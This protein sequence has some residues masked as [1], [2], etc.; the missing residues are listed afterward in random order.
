[1]SD[2]HHAESNVVPYE[3]FLP[4]EWRAFNNSDAQAARAIVI[5]L[6][7]IFVIGIGLYTFVCM[8]L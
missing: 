2:S 6:L 8:T 7:S 5:L 3:L 1:M 4:E